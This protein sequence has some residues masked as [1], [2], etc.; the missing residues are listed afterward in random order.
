MSKSLLQLEVMEATLQ[1]LRQTKKKKKAKHR[2]IVERPNKLYVGTE[3][4]LG[5]WGV[6]A[7]SNTDAP[8]HQHRLYNKK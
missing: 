6:N 7:V 3:P 5:V 1:L 2:W 4:G 8:E